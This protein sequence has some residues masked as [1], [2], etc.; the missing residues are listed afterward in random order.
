MKD[1]DLLGRTDDET[2]G[3][4]LM[5]LSRLQSQSWPNHL[6]ITRHTVAHYPNQNCAS[7]QVRVISSLTVRFYVYKNLYQLI[8]LDS[9]DVIGSNFD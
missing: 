7:E 6:I 8:L 4:S 9:E 5:I 2:Q 3:G 1:E